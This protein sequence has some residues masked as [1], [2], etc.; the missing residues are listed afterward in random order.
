MSEDR[1]RQGENIITVPDA[2][3]DL[4]KCVVEIK[5]FEDGCDPSDG[6]GRSVGI[7]EVATA[8]TQL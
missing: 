4:H 2:V 1:F 5:M 8:P 3:S 7:R 6:A